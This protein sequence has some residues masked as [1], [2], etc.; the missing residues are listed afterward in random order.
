M[1]LLIKKEIAYQMYIKKRENKRKNSVY[2]MA[3]IF[4]SRNK[5]MLRL[6]L[7]L[8]NKR[9]GKLRVFH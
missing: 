4:K 1:F 5:I 9:P 8:L 2:K 3:I 7:R 6:T